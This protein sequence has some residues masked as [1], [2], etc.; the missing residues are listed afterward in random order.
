MGKLPFGSL[1]G[2]EIVGAEV[3]FVIGCAL[4]FQNRLAKIHYVCPYTPR[5]GFLER[6]HPLSTVR[7]TRTGPETT[8]QTRAQIF[9]QSGIHTRLSM[10]RRGAHTHS[11]PMLSE[12]EG[13]QRLK[14]VEASLGR[15]RFHAASGSSLEGLSF[16]LPFPHSTRDEIFEGTIVADPLSV[17]VS[18]FSKRIP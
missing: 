7:G 13:A 11:W 12:A 4:T 2:K 3:A 6:L 5:F 10:C 16:L 15:V 14:Q 18:A 17:V 9:N 8:I 1:Q